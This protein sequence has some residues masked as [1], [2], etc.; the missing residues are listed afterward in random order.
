[1][2]NYTSGIDG[3]PSSDDVAKS[4]HLLTS[5]AHQVS[6]ETCT[7]FF[8]TLW[9]YVHITDRKASSTA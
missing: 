4:S 3:S 5:D 6:L 2:K 1:M 7:K 9:L 8:T